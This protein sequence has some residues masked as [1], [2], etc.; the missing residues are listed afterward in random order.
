M[1]LLSIFISHSEALFHIT[2][3]E[4]ELT[5]QGRNPQSVQNEQSEQSE[6]K[7]NEDFGKSILKSISL[8]GDLKFEEPHPI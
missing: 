1:I 7:T 8:Q 6:M 3:E 4:V 2:L 5:H